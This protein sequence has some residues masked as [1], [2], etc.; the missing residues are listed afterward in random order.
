MSPEQFDVLE[1]RT[2]HRPPHG[3]LMP[4]ARFTGYDKCLDHCRQVVGY[5]RAIER[6]RAAG[7]GVGE[8][9]LQATAAPR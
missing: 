1:Q 6:P 9:F 8:P 5:C 3:G 7:P 4:V 2:G